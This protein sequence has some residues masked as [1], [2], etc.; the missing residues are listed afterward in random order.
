MPLAIQ[1]IPYTACPPPPY[2]DTSQFCHSGCLYCP[3]WFC[4]W[5]IIFCCLPFVFL[6][7]FLT[8]LLFWFLIVASFVP[9]CFAYPKTIAQFLFTASWTFAAFVG[10]AAA[11]WP[12]VSSDALQTFLDACVCACVCYG[13]VEVGV[14]W[15]EAESFSEKDPAMHNK[16]ICDEGICKFVT[17]DIKIATIAAGTEE[18]VFPVHSLSNSATVSLS[19][20][21]KKLAWCKSIE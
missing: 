3:D 5:F 15:P 21:N 8:F 11:D 19:S 9:F 2:L 20:P 1:L 6:R 16:L 13:V 17:S 18:V 7:F 4:A 10:C 14:L 12:A